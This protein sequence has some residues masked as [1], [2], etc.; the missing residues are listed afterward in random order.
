MSPGSVDGKL[1]RLLDMAFGARA[2]AAAARVRIDNLEKENISQSKRL[3]DHGKRIGKT[4]T[5]LSRIWGG[6]AVLTTTGLASIGGIAAWVKN[7]LGGGSS[8]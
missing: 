7:I 4:E 1:D 6:I 2:D 5:G 3:D 8:G